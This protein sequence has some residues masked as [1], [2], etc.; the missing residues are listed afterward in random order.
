M[1]GCFFVMPGGVRWSDAKKNGLNPGVDVAG[2]V[3]GGCHTH[4][5]GKLLR[6][7]EWGNLGVRN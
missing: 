1:L 6:S 5:Q 2:G 4:I 3:L 7:K